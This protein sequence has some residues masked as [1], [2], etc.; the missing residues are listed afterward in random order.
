VEADKRG[1]DMDRRDPSKHPT[2]LKCQNLCSFTLQV[3][4]AG[5][6]ENESGSFAVSLDIRFEKLPPTGELFR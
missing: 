4:Q 5:G 2:Y 1:K 3:P 6:A